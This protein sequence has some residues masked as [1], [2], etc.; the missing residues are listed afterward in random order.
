[1]TALVIKSVRLKEACS[2]QQFGRNGGRVGAR[3]HTPCV[4]AGENMRLEDPGRTRE[5]ERMRAWSDLCASQA[6]GHTTDGRDR[7]VLFE[8]GAPADHAY[9]LA[10]GAIEILQPGA[11]GMSVVVKILSVRSASCA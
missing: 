11:D 10:H 6:L 5:R 4:S 1:M 8:K 9:L 2:P 7:V 3:R